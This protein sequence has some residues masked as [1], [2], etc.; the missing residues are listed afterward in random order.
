MVNPSTEPC[1]CSNFKVTKTA[2][3]WKTYDCTP[4]S[5]MSGISYF[6]HNISFDPGFYYLGLRMTN[7]RDSTWVYASQAPNLCIDEQPKTPKVTSPVVR[8]RV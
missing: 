7:D 8:S 3:T 5:I 6:S 2:I 1:Q 4:V